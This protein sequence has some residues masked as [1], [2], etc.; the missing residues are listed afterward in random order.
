VRTIAVSGRC[1]CYRATFVLREE[2]IAFYLCHCTDC[3]AKP[4]SAFCQT[5][6][7]RRKALSDVDGPVHEHLLERSDGAGAHLSHCTNCLTILWAGRT[8]IPTIGGLNAGCLD[9]VAGLT[10]YGNMW[11]RSARPWVR[12]APGPQFEENPGEPMAMV[13]AWQGRPDQ[14]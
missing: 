1:R 2:P 4:G 3:Q 10:P 14:D 12:M 13:H 6:H 5:M 11:T 7:I 8:E 9:D